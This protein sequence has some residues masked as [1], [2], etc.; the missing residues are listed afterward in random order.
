MMIKAVPDTNIIISSVFWRGN[1]H[2]VMRE[3]MAKK[4]QIITSPSIIEEA[5]GKL[6][7]KFKFPESQLQEYVRILM[8]F[9]EII[10]PASKFDAVR[11]KKDNIILECAYD[12]K[13]DYIITGDKHLLDLKEFK[14]IKIVTPK[15]FLGILEG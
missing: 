4:F 2:K 13:S 10:T 1:P 14:G 9:C 15:E 6:R 8:A 3:G 12:G 5:T 11:D 7:F